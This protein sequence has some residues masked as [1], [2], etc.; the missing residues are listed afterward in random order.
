M[1]RIGNLIMWAVTA[2]FLTCTIVLL[3]DTP[4]RQLQR[5]LRQADDAWHTGT[6]P[7]LQAWRK[8]YWGDPGDP[9]TC[10]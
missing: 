2:L 8:G 4:E 3:R 5:H 6:L 1:N 7:V 9:S 10:R